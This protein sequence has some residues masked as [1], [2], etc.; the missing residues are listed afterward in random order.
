MGKS[1]S[2]YISDD[3]LAEWVRKKVE[4]GTFRSLGHAHEQGLRLLRE[5]QESGAIDF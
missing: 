2:A 5:E 1:H 4:D 3:D